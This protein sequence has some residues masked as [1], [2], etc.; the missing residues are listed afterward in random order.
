ME[1]TAIRP[2][3]KFIQAGFVATILLIAAAVVVHYQ[4]LGPAGQPPWLPAVAALV[5]LWPLAK[6]IGRLFTKIT[7]SGDKLYFESG[8]LSKQTRIIQ[9]HKIQDVRVHQSLGQRMAGVGDLAIETAGESSRLTIANIDQPRVW[10]ERILELANPG[11][12]PNPHGL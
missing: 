8:A 5:L 11:Q 3:L 10:A 7:I 9:I 4:Y 2:S 12:V 1:G 6:L